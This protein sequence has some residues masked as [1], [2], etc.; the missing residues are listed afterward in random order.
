MNIPELLERIDD[1]FD[2]VLAKLCQIRADRS[3][4]FKASVDDEIYDLKYDLEK[5]A[6]QFGV[7]LYS[8]PL[9]IE[10]LDELELRES[11]MDAINNYK[12]AA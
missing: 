12:G 7:I 11:D 2:A 8:N 10:F 5:V 4:P 6:K 9:I 1:D 3:L